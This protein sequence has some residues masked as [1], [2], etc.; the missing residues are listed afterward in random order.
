MYNFD[1]YIINFMSIAK[2][3]PHMLNYLN[4][5]TLNTHNFA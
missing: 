3:K 1:I 4:T 2:N 5:H